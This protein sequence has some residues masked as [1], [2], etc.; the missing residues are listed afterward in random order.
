ME[1]PVIN[2]LLTRRSIR[3]Y[4]PNPVEPELLDLILKAGTYAPTGRGSQ[5][6]TIVAVT[7]EAD[8]QALQA[9]NCAARGGSGDP[10]Y[11]APTILLVFADPSRHTG[12]E[13][14]VCVLNTMM[15]ASPALGAASCWIHG[16]YEMFQLPQGQALLRKWGLP[17]DLRGVGALAL[18]YAGCPLPQEPQPR[19]EGYVVKV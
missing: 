19:R 10:Y 11:G 5:S 2:T 15:V 17:E 14:A 4:R 1:N 3:Q 18:G 16:E 9:L 7:N 8:R 12:V 6:P 13:D